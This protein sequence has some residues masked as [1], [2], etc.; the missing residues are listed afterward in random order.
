MAQV[1]VW[2]VWGAA[3]VPRGPGDDDD[4]SDSDD[5]D[6][7]DDHDYIPGNQVYGESYS[8]GQESVTTRGCENR[9]DNV[10]RSDGGR[11]E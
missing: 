7:S 11:A 8:S 5:D 4:D 2:S 6:D 1:S 9:G 10:T 3:G